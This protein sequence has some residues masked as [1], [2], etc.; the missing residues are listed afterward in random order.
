MPST[1]LDDE[2]REALNKTMQ[3]HKLEAATEFKTHKQFT[4][5][6]KNSKVSTVL[7]VVFYFA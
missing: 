6:A 1:K 7:H 3:T 5:K 2:V 4:K